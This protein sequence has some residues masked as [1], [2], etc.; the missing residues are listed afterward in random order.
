MFFYSNERA[1]PPHV[2]VVAG[3]RE[4]KLSLHD[5]TVAVNVGFPAHELGDIIR[6]LRLHRESLI[7]A[8]HEHFGN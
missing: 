4:A 5:L 3:N 2:H 7:E 6:H 8:W 1:E